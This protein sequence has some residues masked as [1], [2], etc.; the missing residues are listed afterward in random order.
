APAAITGFVPGDTLLVA[1]S[2][3]NIVTQ[4]SMLEGLAQSGRLTAIHL[5]DAGTPTLSLSAAQRSAGADVLARIAT[6]YQLA[7]GVT[8]IA[9]QSGSFDDAAQWSGGSVPDA[10]ADAVIDSAGQPTVTISGTHALHTLANLAGHFILTG[11]ILQVGQL[12][13]ESSLAWNGGSIALDGSDADSSG[14]VNGAGATLSILA[15]GQQIGGT[16]DFANAG[17]MLISGTGQVALDTPLV[18]TGNLVVTQGTLELNAGGR[19]TGSIVA[20]PGGNIVFGGGSFAVTGGYAG[21]STTI[22]GGT[23]DVSAVAGNFRTLLLSAGA[24]ALSTAAADSNGP[25]LQAGGTLDGSGSFVA[26][27]GAQLSGGVQTG[28][29]STRLLGQSTISGTALDGGRTLRNDG[30]LTWSSGDIL[31]GGGDTAAV[32]HGA[33]L[34]N[35][36]VLRITAQA[37]IGPANDGSGMVTNAGLISVQAGAGSATMKASLLNAG[38]VVVESGTLSLAGPVSGGGLFE[39]AGGAALAFANL[40]GAGET[41]RFLGGGGT[42]AIDQTGPF[43]MPVAGFVAGDVLDLTALDFAAGPS[44]RLSGGT[45]TVS[46]GTHSAMLSLIGSYAASGFQL[47]GDAHGGVLAQY[48]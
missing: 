3:S 34:S 1:D 7:S 48:S 36:G 42:L 21:N 9:E 33:T 45:L 35:T 20:Q 39:I 14:L 37:T 6:P 28:P 4:L 10:D 17:A 18:N 40:V 29:G 22:S 16:G 24:L 32:I 11:G 15:N 41:L 31:A 25:L 47:T 46:D 8:W 30:A 12:D 13:N 23:L 5:T 38:I 43:A 26:F 2:S 19:S 27:A 44:A